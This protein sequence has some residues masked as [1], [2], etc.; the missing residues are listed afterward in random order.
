MVSQTPYI[1]AT[2][3]FITA[4]LPMVRRKV[5]TVLRK[6]SSQPQLLS[7]FI[8]ELMGFD[9]NLRDE[10]Q[11]DDLDTTRS[12]KGITWE[13]LV[14]H[15]GFAHWLQV[16]K[17]F[18]LARYQSIIDA[19]DNGDL[20]YDT[21][22]SS[23]TRPTKAA[24][25]VNDLLETITDRYRG[26]SSFSQKLRFLIDIQIS[27]FDSFHSRLHSSLEAYL[28][29]T[30]TFGRTVHGLSPAD[31]AS[32]EGVAGLDRLCR[33]FGSAD[34]LERAMRDWSDDVFFLDLW[35]ELQTRTNNPAS[36][37]NK[38]RTP[39]DT[40]AHS[41][42]T[43]IGGNTTGAL[44]D[45]TASAYNRLRI[46]SETVLVETLTHTVREALR[47]YSRL[48]T[49]STSISASTS[50]TLSSIEISFDL[51]P[52][53]TILGDSLSFLSRALAI[54][55]LRHISREVAHSIETYL[56]ER[57]LLPHHFSAVG[58]RQFAADLNAIA[59]TFEKYVGREHGAAGLRALQEAAKLLTL[60]VQTVTTT[61][62]GASD[63]EGSGW[64]DAAW[65][66]DD[67]GGV[68]KQSHGRA[69][70][71]RLG[72]W[73]VERRL[74]ADNESARMVL[75]DLSV[76]SLTEAEARK[77]LRCRVELLNA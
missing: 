30:S 53:L 58:A 2:S 65:N 48:N 43:I 41:S 47:P 66:V 61:R 21:V 34:Y 68:H 35:A 22:P 15:D 40:A 7:H 29:M 17:D 32:L 76:D 77:V 54:L 31:A 9:S 62:D 19:P 8:H 46:R 63:G 5:F 57:V 26:L 73:D 38:Y 67:E 25:R 16:E 45:E 44:F 55:P 56:W 4:L 75:E 74:F 24:I 14:L 13:V 12:W 1:D 42:S 3:A 6:V 18:A 36:T 11:Y 51:T 70:E 60:P 50:D 33:V 71:G 59:R 52:V 49:W 28:S 27:I 72:L 10:W 23:S 69:G 39:T 20:D 37:T 64:A